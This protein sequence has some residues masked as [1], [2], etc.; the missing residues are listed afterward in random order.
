[1]GLDIR[2]AL[3]WK[4]IWRFESKG[5]IVEESHQLWYNQ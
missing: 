1:M 3:L 4:L 5:I 2:V